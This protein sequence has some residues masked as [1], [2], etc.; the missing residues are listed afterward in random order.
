MKLKE[1]SIIQ[2]T[3]FDLEI[4]STINKITEHGE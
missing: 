1:G 2:T 4:E 3:T